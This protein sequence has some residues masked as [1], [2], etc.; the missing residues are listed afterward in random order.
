MEED[1]K[2]KQHELTADTT[3]RDAEGEK[4]KADMKA[5]NEMMERREAERKPAMS[6]GWR[7]GKPKKKRR[8]DYEKMMAA[9]KTGQEKSEAESKATDA[10]R[11]GCKRFATRLTPTR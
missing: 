10:W 5:F 8:A 2:V 6:R 3:K 9:R 11:Q 4:R 7:S 1:M